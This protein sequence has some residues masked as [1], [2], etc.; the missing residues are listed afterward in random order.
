[1]YFEASVGAGCGEMV[2]NM[3]DFVCPHLQNASL[4]VSNRPTRFVFRSRGKQGYF[5]AR[6]RN[7]DSGA[8]PHFRRGAELTGS[9]HRDFFGAL[10]LTRV[11]YS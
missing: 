9:Y 7:G 3:P 11:V 4:E 10:T 6:G 1:M 2:G 5:Y 8:Q